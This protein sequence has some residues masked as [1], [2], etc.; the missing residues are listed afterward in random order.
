MSKWNYFQ[1]QTPGTSSVFWFSPICQT[2]F[3]CNSLASLLQTSPYCQDGKWLLPRLSK[4][5]KTEHEST[6][7]L[8]FYMYIQKGYG[9]RMVMVGNF[10][11]KEVSF[12][13]ISTQIMANLASFLPISY[14]FC[15]AQTPTVPTFRLLSFGCLESWGFRFPNP[16]INSKMVP[17]PFVTNCQKV[18]RALSSQNQSFL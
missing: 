6:G 14:G 15:S 3:K 16:E 7:V 9:Q 12:I 17:P 13:L 1:S 11:I 5:V 2:C 10:P 4:N 18:K 8:V